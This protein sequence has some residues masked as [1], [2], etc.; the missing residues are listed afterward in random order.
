M[1]GRFL[2]HEVCVRAC[3]C[4]KGARQWEGGGWGVECKSM[5]S[6]CVGGEG[7]SQ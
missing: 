3:V 1:C 5:G 7:A 4:V 2:D 6:V